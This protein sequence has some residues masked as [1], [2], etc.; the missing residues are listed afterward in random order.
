MAPRA[1]LGARQSDNAKTASGEAYMDAATQKTEA[2][3][4]YIQPRING[5][6]R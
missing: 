3:S 6:F 2:G 4:F 5:Y 1:V